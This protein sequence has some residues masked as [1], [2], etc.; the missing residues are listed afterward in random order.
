MK[1]LFTVLIL[2]FTL[3]ASAQ[4]QVKV[5]LRGGANLATISQDF[6]FSD[7]EFETKFLAGI[8]VGAEIDYVL[9]DQLSVRSGLLFTRKGFAVDLEE[10]L[11][12]PG[13][14]AEVDGYE[15][16]KISYLQ[17]PLNVAYNFG[18]IKAVGGFY[19]AA[20]IGG[21]ID[22]DYTATLVTPGGTE[23]E[24]EDRSIDIEFNT[25]EID[26][27]NQNPEVNRYDFG[28]NLGLEYDLDPVSIRLEYAKGFSNLTL[29]D[30]EDPEFDRDDFKITT[31]TISIGVVYFLNIK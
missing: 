17:I 12:E 15:R 7:D 19:L 13:V 10:E 8:H 30:P 18:P 31:S 2:L 4:A 29:D 26:P 21:E 14:S 11:S 22:Q 3:A 16:W 9:S 25:G 27:N 20:G 6:A 28:F 5:G 24:I 23:T 1:Q